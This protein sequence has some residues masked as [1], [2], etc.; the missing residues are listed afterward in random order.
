MWIRKRFREEGMC[1]MI[2]GCEIKNQKWLR[3]DGVFLMTEWI[4]EVE[5]KLRYWA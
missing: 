1:L 5:E 4:R 3:G 2:S